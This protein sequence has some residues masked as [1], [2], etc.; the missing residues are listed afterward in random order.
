VAEILPEDG[1]AGTLIG[2]VNTTAGP[3]GV[4]V[5][6]DGVFDI[7]AAAPTVADL[8]NAADPLALA[9]SGG[10]H[11]GALDELL[12]ALLAPIDLQAIK[13]A[14]VTFAVSL[15]ERLIEEHA[16]GDLSRAEQVRGDI[17][18]IRWS[19]GT[20]NSEDPVVGAVKLI[21]KCPC[22]V[23]CCLLELG[24]LFF[25]CGIVLCVGFGKWTQ[26]PVQSLRCNLCRV[27]RR[28]LEGF[29]AL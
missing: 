20:H 25:A 13:A 27:G 21:V 10:I 29:H 18:N 17:L 19:Y 15:L 26:I 23:Q 7:T 4:A 6:A 28:H 5:R 22:I 3:S 14:G 11:L 8:C 2:R 9:R 1:C 24:Q 16:K 12:P